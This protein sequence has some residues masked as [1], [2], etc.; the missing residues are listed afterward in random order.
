MIK[1]VAWIRTQNDMY[2]CQECHDDTMQTLSL[3]FEDGL[4]IQDYIEFFEDIDE[5]EFFGNI[6]VMRKKSNQIVLDINEY[7]FPGLASFETK[8]E[9]MIQIMNEYRRLVHSKADRIEISFDEH[10]KVTITGK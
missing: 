8:I 3:L 10:D 5:D 4:G 6:C 1:K 2:T 9:N 7:V